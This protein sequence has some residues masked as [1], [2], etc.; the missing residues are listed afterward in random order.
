M[1]SRFD[2]IDKKVVN[3]CVHTYSTHEYAH[4]KGFLVEKILVCMTSKGFVSGKIRLHALKQCK[5]SIVSSF[6]VTVYPF[7]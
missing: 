3:Y 6:P 5:C 4:K 7:Y 1:R 2:L